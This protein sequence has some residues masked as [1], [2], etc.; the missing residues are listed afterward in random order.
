MK[1][2]AGLKY[3]LVQKAEEA[4][5]LFNGLSVGGQIEGPMELNGW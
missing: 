3:Q 4:D 5:R 2:K 1:T